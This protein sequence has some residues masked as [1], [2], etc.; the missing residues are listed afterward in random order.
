[1]FQKSH[2]FNQA[3]LSRMHIHSLSES[4]WLLPIHVT[5]PTFSENKCELWNG[6][7]EADWLTD[8]LTVSLHLMQVCWKLSV[9]LSHHN[10]TCSGKTGLIAFFKKKIVTNIKVLE[11]QFVNISCKCALSVKLSNHVT[12]SGKPAY[13]AFF[14][15]NVT[16][17]KLFS[18]LEAPICGAVF[19]QSI[20]MGLWR[21]KSL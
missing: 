21:G 10:V 19:K 8:R 18:S 13:T 4:V 11:L 3:T 14:L 2:C 15:K 9:K 7:T 17:I 1:M 16:N 20:V 5:F 12:C 6:Y